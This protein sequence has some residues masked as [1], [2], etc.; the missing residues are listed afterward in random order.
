[1]SDRSSCP[2]CGK[3]YLNIFKLRRQIATAHGKPNLKRKSI[4]NNIIH[5]DYDDDDQDGDDSRAKTRH[6][7]T[8]Q[9]GDASEYEHSSDKEQDDDNDA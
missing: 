9:R 6:I 3:Y 7:S 2:A 4:I 5:K 8:R 1:M